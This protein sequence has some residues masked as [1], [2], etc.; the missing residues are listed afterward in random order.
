[1]YALLLQKNLGEGMVSKFK[2]EE[3]L[4]HP[5][6]HLQNNMH[7]SIPCIYALILP[8]VVLTKALKN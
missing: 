7:L 4:I 6:E 3:A 5:K 1:M 8:M 2:A